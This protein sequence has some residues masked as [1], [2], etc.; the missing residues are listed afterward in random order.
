MLSKDGGITSSE[1]ESWFEHVRESALMVQPVMFT[2]G[3]DVDSQRAMH[4]SM[5]LDVTVL[6]LHLLG[7]GWGLPPRRMEH[8]SMDHDVMFSTMAPWVVEPCY[9]A[10]FYG[11]RSHAP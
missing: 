7:S 8:G 9:K 10:W 6:H 2:K 5:D 11:Q 1:K 3:H 4:Q